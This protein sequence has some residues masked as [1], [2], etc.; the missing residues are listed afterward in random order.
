MDAISRARLQ[1]ARYGNNAPVAVNVI[2]YYAHLTVR[3]KL[4]S[5]LPPAGRALSISY[6]AGQFAA[7]AA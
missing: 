1:P 4:P 7:R 6:L 5:D 3:G 2:W